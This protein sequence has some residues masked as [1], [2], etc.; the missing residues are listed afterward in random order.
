MTIEQLKQFIALKEQGT[1]EKAGK[2]CFCTSATVLKNI[3]I[4][5]SNLGYN[6]FRRSAIQGGKR[7][8]ILTE[9]GEVLYKKSKILIAHYNEFLNMS[10]ALK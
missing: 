7:I 4:L 6:L 1:Q 10:E 3:R 9:K 8:D 2:V 5:E